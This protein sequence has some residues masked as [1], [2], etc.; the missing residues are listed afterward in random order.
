MSAPLCSDCFCYHVWPAPA[1][2]CAGTL[3]LRFSHGPAPKRLFYPPLPLPLMFLHT[4]GG[5]AGGNFDFSI[6]A[7]QTIQPIQPI[8]AQ[9]AGQR[10]GKKYQCI[11]YMFYIYMY[12][13][14]TRGIPLK[15]LGVFAVT[16]LPQSTKPWLG[17][18]KGATIFLVDVDLHGS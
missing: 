9:Q 14:A 15:S 1:S 18:T 16:M 4:S 11:F 13:F 12:I 10:P 5:R 3:V 6:C 17:K 2:S 8:C 7:I